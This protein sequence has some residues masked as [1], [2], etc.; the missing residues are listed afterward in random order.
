MR[1]S[2]LIV[3]HRKSWLKVNPH[4]YYKKINDG[5]GAGGQKPFDVFIMGMRNG[6]KEN[7]AKEFK[8]HK[9]HRAFP[10]REIQPHQIMELTMAARAGAVATIFIG[11]RFM[12]DVDT[13][14]RLGLRLRRISVDIELPIRDIVEM[15][16]SGQKS[17]PGL[18][19][20]LKEINGEQQ[21]QG[22]GNDAGQEAAGCS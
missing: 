9:S 13:Q 10:L 16:K 3:A 20:L 7:W 15:V 22:Q 2:G 5:M 14:K 4:D 19:Y 1:E 21:G 6:L 12:M 11:V 18:P 17:I 8:L